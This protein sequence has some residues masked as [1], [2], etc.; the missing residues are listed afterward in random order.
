MIVRVHNTEALHSTA[1]TLPRMICKLKLILMVKYNVCMNRLR[2]NLKSWNLDD[3]TG[4]FIDSGVLI[5]S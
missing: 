5:N 4:T 2:D 3:V 1:K